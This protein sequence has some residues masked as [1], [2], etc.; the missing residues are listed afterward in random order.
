MSRTVEIGY[1]PGEPHVQTHIEGFGH[2]ADV[3]EG[4]AV[5]IVSC[6]AAGFDTQK[7]CQDLGPGS[8]ACIAFVRAADCERFCEHLTIEVTE[9]EDVV[10]F[11]PRDIG[12]AIADL[13]P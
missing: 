13:Q 6:W 2:A 12:Q 10:W 5:L 8:G 11:D 3:D 7:S 1:P 4:I 9:D